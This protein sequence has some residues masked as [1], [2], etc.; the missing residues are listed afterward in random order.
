MLRLTAFLFLSLYFLQNIHSQAI[1]RSISAGFS[2][3]TDLVKPYGEDKWLLAGRGEPEPGAYFQDTLFVAVIGRDGQIHL[4][5]NLSMP[6]EEVHF[7]HDALSLPDGGI[8]AC[9]EST[10][11]DVGGYLVSVQRLDAQG[12]LVWGKTSGF[13]F[14]ESRL[15]EQWFLAQDGNLL[16]AAYNEIWKLDVNT[17]DILWKAALQ[18]VSGGTISPYEMALIPGT[19]DFFALGNPDFQLW[20][21]TGNPASPVYVLANSMELPG[22]RNRLTL[23]PNGG[24]YCLQHYPDDQLEWID[25]NFNHL[26]LPIL[27]SSIDVVGMAASETNFYLAESIGYFTNRIRRFDVSGQNPVELPAPSAWL[28][29]QALSYNKDWLAV[30]GIDRTGAAPGTYI[31]QGSA[32][33]LR[34]FPVATPGPL[35]QTPNASVTA[36]EQLQPL[37]TTSIPAFPTGYLYNFTGG[38]FRVKI[39]NLGNTPIDRVGVNVV[40]NLN[41][42]YDICYNVSARQRQFSNLNLDPGESV[43]VD[44]GD[45]E[46]FG[47]DSVPAKLCFWTSS[48]NERPDAQHE[49]DRFCQPVTYIVAVQEPRLAGLAFSPNPSDEYTLI[50]FESE[51][52]GEKWQIFDAAGRLAAAGICPGGPT[53]RLETASL[54]AG[55]YWVQLGNYT[56]KLVVQH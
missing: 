20:H 22:Y 26:A 19:E 23:S 47:Q 27:V 28:T 7:W 34:T 56:G 1:E 18:G 3:I 30:A 53:L 13:V 9:F 52:P 38:D 8:L 41:Q 4:H 45:V 51:M 46:A 29:P 14:G 25:T 31:R 37:D 42:F 36:V 43:W 33:W 40:F 17:G 16:G 24:F 55:F 12:N 15:P 6:T 21:K 35:S 50:T 2:T 32:G 54:A 48:P 10:L 5:K 49:D 11:C 44:F 39:S